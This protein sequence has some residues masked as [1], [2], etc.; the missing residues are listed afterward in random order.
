VA[1]EGEGVDFFYKIHNGKGCWWLKI[2]IFKI[3]NIHGPSFFCFFF[4]FFFFFTSDVIITIY[5]IGHEVLL[6]GHFFPLF[7]LYI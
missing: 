7:P 6:D 3:L 5:L 1:R 4:F 2:A